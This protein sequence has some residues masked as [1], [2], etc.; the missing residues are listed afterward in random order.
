MIREVKAIGI[1][2]I[3]LF[4]ILLV[5]VERTIDLGLENGNLKGRLSEITEVK[6]L[7]NF[8]TVKQAVQ[9]Y[10]IKDSKLYT[11]IKN[12]T[13]LTYKIDNKY[14]LYKNSL[15]SYLNKKK[16]LN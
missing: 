11:A 8:I 14:I 9:Q 7:D 5:F 3:V 12:K 15:E 4:L 2:S 13:I 1:I 16:P 10:K 6:S